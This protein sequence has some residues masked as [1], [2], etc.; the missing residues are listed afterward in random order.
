MIVLKEEY[1]E[2]QK[3]SWIFGYFGHLVWYEQSGSK[4]VDANDG[5]SANQGL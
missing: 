4:S 1:C 5:R 2:L 3:T